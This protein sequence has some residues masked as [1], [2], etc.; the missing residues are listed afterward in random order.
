MGVTRFR[1]GTIV[2]MDRRRQRAAWVN[3]D[4]HRFTLDGRR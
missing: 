2:T 1:G 3:V 4:G